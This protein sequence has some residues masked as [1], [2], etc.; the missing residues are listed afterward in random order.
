MHGFGI[1][2]SGNHIFLM[3]IGVLLGILVGVLPGLGR[4]QWRIAA[5]A[6]HLRNAA[7]IGDHPALFDVLGRV[8]RRLGHVHP[9]QYS[10]R[11]FLGRDHVRRLSDGAR[12]QADHGAGDG[13]R[14][15]RL[16]RAGRRRS[17]YALRVMGRAS[18]AGLWTTRIFRGL[19]SGVC[20]LRGHG[21]HAADQDAGVARDRLC[22]G[23]RRDRHGLRQRAAHHGHR[24]DG[25]GRQ[26]RGRRH[27]PVR[28]RRV[29]DCRG[30]G[31]SRQGD[32]FQSGVARSLPHARGSSAIWL[33]AVAQRGDRLLDGHYPGRPD[34]RIVHEL[35][36]RQASFAPA[37]E[38]R[39]GRAG[40]HR[41][42]GSRGSCRRHQRPAS[43]A[44][45]GHSRDRRPPP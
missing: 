19:F 2:L 8:V 42:S 21:R 14:L 44:V 36:H 3:V 28:H 30:R 38:F 31:I 33:G 6:A 22:A 25:E 32:L 45:A 34:R 7:G 27:G 43:D 24:R 29:A 10:G 1:A 9:V 26:L 41:R 17:H 23:G 20:E 39:Q 37:R 40:G 35:R 5:A 18:G 12:R 11:A 13:F 15:G 4:A 16:W